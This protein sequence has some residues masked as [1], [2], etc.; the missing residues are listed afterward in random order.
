M[1]A[2]TE[3]SRL[4]SIPTEKL[5]ELLQMQGLPAATASDAGK[6]PVVNDD[7]AW[8]LGEAQ[9]GAGAL[10]VQSDGDTLD[11]TWSEIRAAVISG[12]G[13]TVLQITDDAE[14]LDESD[15]VNIYT[16][17]GVAVEEG[18]YRVGVSKG[19]TTYTFVAQSQDGVL[20]YDD[21]DEDVT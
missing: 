8:E 12:R 16:L 19:A 13:V 18:E 1:G 4:D 3:M 7:G 21:S 9:A 2:N 15:A 6:V 10:I 20:T 14:T 17:I 5:N 11:K